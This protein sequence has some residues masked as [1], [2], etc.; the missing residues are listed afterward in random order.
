M[1][2]VIKYAFLA[3][4]GLVL[5]SHGTDNAVNAVILL[6]NVDYTENTNHVGATKHCWVVTSLCLRESVFTE[7]LPKSGLHNPV[8]PLLLACIT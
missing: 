4:S 5:Y 3:A 6:R 7:P 1:L 8:V 2:Q